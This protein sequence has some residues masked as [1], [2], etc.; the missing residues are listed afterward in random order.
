MSRL[1]TTFAVT[2]MLLLGSCASTHTDPAP[3]GINAKCPIS[4]EAIEAD[5]PTADFHGQ[6]VAFCCSNCIKKWDAMSDA[7]RQAKLDAMK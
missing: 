3:A 6:K 2:A 1:F 7:D 5:S 4:G